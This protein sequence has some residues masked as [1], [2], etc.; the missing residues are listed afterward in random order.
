MPMTTTVTLAFEGAPACQSCQQQGVPVCAHVGFNAAAWDGLAGTRV[1]L[2]GLDPDVDTYVH[3]VRT[4]EI[5]ADR[6]T[7]TLTVD[8]QRSPGLDLV[9]NLSVLDGPKALVR[10][11][12]DETG[13]MLSEG[14]YD[15]ALYLG[16]AVW[17]GGAPFQVVGIDFPHRDPVT[18][19]SGAHPDWQVA[20]VQPRPLP[21]PVTSVI[22]A[23]Q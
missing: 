15:A 14:G 19:S 2:P 16:Q 7:A 11:V 9:R 8:T 21:E 3:L 1:H 4:V 22:A 13:T 10:T 5:S 17:I 6:K 20:R 23:P 18:G 12:D